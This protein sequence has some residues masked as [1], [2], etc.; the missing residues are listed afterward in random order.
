V[1]AAYHGLQTNGRIQGIQIKALCSALAM[2][3]DTGYAEAIVRFL[4]PFCFA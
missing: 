4:M 1:H 2:L 3:W